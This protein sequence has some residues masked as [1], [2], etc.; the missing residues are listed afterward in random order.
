MKTTCDRAR[1]WISLCV[2]FLM[3]MA[4]MVAG[5]GA[6]P[7]HA[8]DAEAVAEWVFASNP[9]PTSDPSVDGNTF[10]ATGGADLTAT[11]RPVATDPLASYSYDSTEKSI[12]YQGWD[13]GT[14]TKGWLVVLSTKGFTDLTV[15]SQQRSSGSGPRDFALQISTDGQANWQDVGAWQN[16]DGGVLAVANAWSSAGAIDK[17]PL[18]ASAAGKDQLAI[19][20]LVTSTSSVSSGEGGLVGATGSSRIGNILV[21]GIPT[22]E[23]VERPTVSTGHLP[24]TGSQSV[25]PDATI[26]VTYN[27]TVT[28]VSGAEASIVDDHGTPVSGVHLSAAGKVVTIAH[29][30]LALSSTYAV[31]LPKGAVTGADAIAPTQDVVWTFNTADPVRDSVAEWNFGGKDDRGV[32]WATGG[33]YKDRSALTSVGTS[34]SYEYDSGDKNVSTYGWGSGKDTKHWL[35]SLSTAGFKDVTVSS[36]Q[37]SSG[38]GP[39]DFRLEVST[40]RSHWNV[41]P[42]GT[43][44]T[45]THSY[46]CPGN[47]CRLRNVPLGA[48][49][50]NAPVL[51]LRWIMSSNVPTNTVDNVT[52]GGYGDNFIRN[53]VVKGDRL[54]GTPLATPT[55]DVLTA[56]ADGATEVRP[57][58]GVSVR[59]NKQVEIVDAASITITDEAAKPVS[60]TA[61]TV[62]GDT[63]TIAHPAFEL[64]HTYTVTVPAAAVR[65]SDGIAPLRATT[66]SFSSP[67]KTPTAFTMNF[68]GDTRTTMAFAWYTHPSITDSVVEVA[69]A[70]AAHGDAFPTE[71][72]T[73][74]SGTSEVIDTFVTEDDR[75][76]RHTEKY[77]S[78]KVKATGLTPGT[79]Y[80]YRAGDGSDTGWGRSGSFTTDASTAQPFHFIYGSDSQASD[81]GSFLEWQDTFSKAVNKVD[82]PKFLLVS[83]DL[84]DNGDLEEQWQ[85]MLNS[86]ADQF[87]HVPYAPVLGGHEVEDSGTLPNNNFYNHFNEPRDAG[88]TGA[89]EGSV[90]SFEYG[91][92]LFMQFNSQ[93]EGGLDKDGN[94]AWVDPQF[95]KQLDWMRRT[96]AQTDRHWKFVAMHKG[97]YSAGENACYWEGDRLAFYEKYLVP[98]FQQTGVDVV[99]EA[100]D[101]MYMRSHQLLDGKPVDTVTDEHGNI[102]LQYDVTNPKGVLYLMPNAL[103]NKFYHKPDGCSD[104]FA[105]I[106]VQPEKKMFVDFSV[107]HDK[108][109]LK[110]YTA[111]VEDEARGDDGLKLFDHYTI[112]RTDS[113]PNPVQNVNA[114]LSGGSVTIKWSA[115]TA[116]SEPV[117]GY[118]VYETNDQLGRNWTSY[119]TAV[120][121]Q[122]DYSITQPVSDDPTLRYEFVVKAVGTKDNSAPVSVAAAVASDDT[123]APSV[124]GTPTATATSQVQVSLT[125]QPSTDNVAV[126]G[127]KVFRDGALVGRTT[128]AAFTDTG[129]NPGATYAYSVSAHD[130]GGNESARSAEAS[131]TMPVT[132]TTSSPQRPFGQHTTYAPG[133]IKPS[134]S[135]GQLDSE[136]A[137][138]YDAWKGAYLTQNPYEDDQYYVYYNGQGEAGDEVPDAV[139]TSES[140]GYGMLI[141]AIM[142]GHDPQAQTLFDGLLRFAKAHP[143]SGNPDLM[144]WQER[145]DGKAIVNSTEVDEDGEEY[146]DDAATDGDLDMAYALLLADQQWGSGGE[147][148]Y[149]AES[150][151]IMNAIM[152]SEVHPD[153]HTL[154][155]GDWTRGEA[156]YSTATR[157]S[158]FVTQHLKDFANASG[159]RR[160]NDV[161]DKTY[162][163]EQSLFATYSPTTGLLPDF[164][165][166][167]GSGYA[168]AG[169]GFLEDE[170]DGDYNWNSSRTPWRIGTDYVMTGAEQP[171]AQLAA[172]NS[173]IKQA[174]GGDPS[175]IAQGYT[176]AGEALDPDTDEAFS[177]PFAVSAMLD[178]SN[179]QWLDALWEANTQNPVTSYFGDSVRLLSLI[180]V[181]GNWWSP[182]GVGAPSAELKPP[183][184]L[185]A[186]ATG[187]TSV[188]LTWTASPSLDVTGYRVYRDG[189]VVATVGS[190][191]VAFH[192]TG[193]APATRYEYSVTALD[194]AGRE[195]APSTPSSVTTQAVVLTPTSTTLTATS[196]AVYGHRVTLTA[197]VTGGATGTVQ[198]LDG[199]RV[200]GAATLTGGKATLA[201]YSLGAGKHSLRAAYVSDGVHAA[202][203]SAARTVSIAKAAVS[204]AKPKVLKGKVV[205]G[206]GKV[207][208]S[209][210]VTGLSSGQISFVSGKRTIAVGQVTMTSKGAVAKAAIL[211][212]VPVG[213]YRTIR[214]VWAGDA[215]HKAGKSRAASKRLTVVRAKP[216]SVKVVAGSF[217]KNT[218]PRALV[219]VGRLTNGQTP[220]GKVKVRVAGRP[221]ITVKLDASMGGMVWVTLKESKKSVRVWAQFRPTDAK[222][223]SSLT[224]KKVVLKAR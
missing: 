212:S 172:M 19:R 35:A 83:G 208:L 44:K 153:E 59:F 190:D 72:V 209:V 49:A 27:K 54:E 68:N 76:S 125:W 50:D 43:I 113:A 91:D 200:V 145:D 194:K 26:S 62:A 94:L 95:T 142:A 8:A 116:S 103:G 73:R 118:R 124:P 169:P 127:Y 100:H 198:F 3:A 182:T 123:Q 193:L 99:L 148:N 139:T 14:G 150:R 164:V 6:T 77:A 55:F 9:N 163:I 143:S 201:L 93:Y 141:T 110:A 199:D 102:V 202:S 130:A 218:Q 20:W 2:A 79:A 30:P 207:V 108:L 122:S 4:A 219:L 7:A 70:D 121:G 195:S 88:G 23:P 211:N 188:D 41:V 158:D 197:T 147:F 165:V 74:F 128:T 89:H 17:L 136:V 57:A 171:K 129:R 78:H 51:Y 5:V 96:A 134:L 126:T 177:A 109:S 111:A 81:L 178:S 46:T 173:W 162:A 106:D 221:S 80:V 10:A 152:A 159:D 191:Q 174:T 34:G 71:G 112:T 97:P 67:V 224:S 217:V 29:A 60:G 183:T 47:T 184:G 37:K 48:D 42:G 222:H 155:L 133:T 170:N 213:T 115:P 40:D 138:L 101:H 180:V 53:I 140:N 157:P 25:A 1:A 104:D 205:W 156:E 69:R 15:S 167:S 160:W 137:G 22:G 132:P 117:R 33:A 176:L 114:A 185:A 168:P 52:V 82:D 151:R 135:Q 107:T 36:E 38:S 16:V 28:L 75:D 186:V 223:V 12:R 119:I 220:V 105:A 120:D 56:P 65:G 210:K 85:W 149:L 189:K 24:A 215:N 90:Y 21:S 11:L 144:A 13:N 61:A 45:I 58:T 154:Q 32:F 179:Q 196:S 31:T 131:V 166:K 84:V 214:A 86:A 192:D 98:V 66:W 39:A 203:I 146:G 204:L 63:L 175:K 206:S 18:P 87:A 216:S 161:I 187:T 181:S 92:A 64:G